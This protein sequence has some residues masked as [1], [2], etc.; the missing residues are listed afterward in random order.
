MLNADSVQEQPLELTGLAPDPL[1]MWKRL[2][3]FL[4]LDEAE[5]RMMRRTSETLLGDA[6]DFVVG[7]V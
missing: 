5:V 3:A 1:Q 2:H 6:A 4:G 7:C